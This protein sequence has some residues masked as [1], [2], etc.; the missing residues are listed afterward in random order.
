VTSNEDK[1]FL[2]HPGHQKALRGEA[3]LGA[4][5]ALASAIPLVPGDLLH[6]DAGQRP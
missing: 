3:V 5:P 2:Q 1:R 6:A 4:V